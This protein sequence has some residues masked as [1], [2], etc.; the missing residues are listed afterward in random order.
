VAGDIFGGRRPDGV[1][2][3]RFR[4]CL[5]RQAEERLKVGPEWCGTEDYEAYLKLSLK[6]YSPTAAR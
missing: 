4:A 2:R 5:L 6:K 3:V 1:R